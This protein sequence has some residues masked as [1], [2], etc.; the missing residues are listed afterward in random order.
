MLF[1]VFR[2]VTTCLSFITSYMS[3]LKY[4]TI[5]MHTI[6]IN[7]NNSFISFF[8]SLFFNFLSPY[9]FLLTSSATL[10]NLFDKSSSIPL[11][12]YTNDSRSCNPCL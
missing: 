4:P 2:T 12:F 5:T 1:L 6:T 3:F 9:I 10:Y 8:C 7:D 11:L